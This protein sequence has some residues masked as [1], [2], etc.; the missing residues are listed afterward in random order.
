MKTDGYSSKRLN[1]TRISA[2]LLTL[3]MVLI[4]AGCNSD[5]GS[6][7]GKGTLA[8]SLTDAPA[9]GFDA[10]NVTVSKVRVHQSNSATENDPGWEEIVL[11]PARKINLL[12]L[13]NGTLEYLGKTPL[14]AGHYTQLRLVLGTGD[15]ANSVIPTDGTE[16]ALDTPSG[17]QSGLKLIDGFDVVEGER[18][19]V[20][21][22]FDACKSVVTRGN[23]SYG[24]KPV[25]RMIPFT[26]NGIGGFVDPALLVDNNVNNVTVSAQSDGTVIRSTVP[27]VETG[28]F[29]LARLEPGYYDVAI[30]ADNH[31]TAIIDNVPVASPTSTAT[32]SSLSAPF[33]LPASATH[34]ISGTI[35]LNPPSTTTVA[36]ATA[37]QS[38][39]G[40]TV[41]VKSQA[42][43]LL[44]AYVLT[45][46]S[47]APLRGVYNL[48]LLPIT[49]S[50]QT[51]VAG[52][53]L[54]EATATGYQTQSVDKNIATADAT[55]SFT[56]TP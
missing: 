21:L 15:L 36:E 34:T 26:L 50:A 28:E 25:M 2:F 38:V 7:S 1:L 35:S 31:V 3:C 40:T 54:L 10:V 5:S 8:V 16:I 24:L 49:L 47:E 14:A 45:L 27:D 53:Y 37:K 46:P 48:G 42:V 55:E 17:M 13:N 11:D 39:A 23:G 33:T 29:F 19:D 52:Q 32:L 56:L 51:G 22:D 41:T 44:N 12:D 43:D 6:S 20:V 4:M 18:A 9:C 30:T